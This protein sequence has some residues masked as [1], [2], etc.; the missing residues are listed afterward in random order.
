MNTLT[1]A[2][3]QA[4][5]VQAITRTV[6]VQAAYKAACKANQEFS[7]SEDDKTHV[8][9]VSESEVYAFFYATDSEQ[10][11]LPVWCEYVTGS[12]AALIAYTFTMTGQGKSPK[13]EAQRLQALAA[14]T[15]KFIGPKDRAHIT[16]IALLMEEAARLLEVADEPTTPPAAP[17][18]P[19]QSAPLA[20]SK[21]AIIYGYATS[22]H[23]GGLTDVFYTFRSGERVLVHSTRKSGKFAGDGVKWAETASEQ[24]D[25]AA[26]IAQLRAVGVSQPLAEKIAED[27]LKGDEPTTAQAIAHGHDAYTVQESA[28]FWLLEYQAALQLERDAT[29]EKEKSK[30]NRRAGEALA[31]GSELNRLAAQ[32]RDEEAQTAEP[33]QAKRVPHGTFEVQSD[34]LTKGATFYY[35]FQ[36]GDRARLFSAF[37]EDVESVQRECYR[38][39]A[40]AQIINT[41]EGEEKETARALW[42]RELSVFAYSLTLE[43]VEAIARDFCPITPRLTL[44]KTPKAQ[45]MMQ[46]TGVIPRDRLSY[47]NWSE[48]D[49]EPTPQQLEEAAQAA[50]REASA[51]QLEPPAADP[52]YQGAARRAHAQAKQAR[53]LAN[54]ARAIEESEAPPLPVNPEDV[55]QAQILRA[56][57][58]SVLLRLA[59]QL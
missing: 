56:L 40:N 5:T 8:I 17:T 31:L 27:Q 20:N 53:A 22:Q 30:Y 3:A 1:P 51:W 37:A 29:S 25:R 9:R 57:V 34:I 58:K 7:A 48:P 50:E 15:S 14:D 13:A 54:L 19:G 32:K 46:S 23:K 59:A 24:T 2:L 41:M 21:S 38:L 16:A 39:Q 44:E 26:L 28:N 36:N 4:L 43:T 12:P 52:L 11:A 18:T 45:T 47:F 33:S 49:A 10:G 42:V 6:Q 55:K 35:K